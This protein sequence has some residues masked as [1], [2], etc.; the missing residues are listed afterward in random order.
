MRIAL[1]VEGKTERAF[2]PYLRESL[3]NRLS[4]NM[5]NLDFLPYDG[6]IPTADKLKRVVERLLANRAKPA[7]HVI[8]LTD[9]YTGSRPPDFVDATDAKNK[10][11]QWVGPEPHFHPHAAQYDF[12]AWLIPYWPDIQ[13]LAGHNRA[14]PSGNPET[15]NH[16]NPPAH[17]IAEVFRTGSRGKAYVKARDAGRILRGKDLST[18]ISQCPELKSFINTILTVCGAD[19]IP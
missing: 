12:E 19:A 2:A 7:D 10:M 11:R 8:A 14:A 16:D 15:I 5:P 1:I 18:S 13:R 3:V 4:G 17:R 9:V 6:R